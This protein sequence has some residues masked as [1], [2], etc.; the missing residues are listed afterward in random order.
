MYG[1]GFFY[2]PNGKNSTT[3]QRVIQS[4][5]DAQIPGIGKIPDT[6]RWKP[7]KVN[8]WTKW[9]DA[10]WI[11]AQD[12]YKKQGIK[13]KAKWQSILKFYLDAASDK[14][15]LLP[16]VPPKKSAMEKAGEK[17]ARMFNKSR[18]EYLKE[19]KKVTKKPKHKERESTVEDLLEIIASN[20]S[21]GMLPTFQPP[22]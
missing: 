20:S 3:G 18:R 11:Q 7:D 2:D 12:A 14:Y 21:V 17:E 8:P 5:W 4:A 19:T 6:I 13:S 15:H 9:A 10:A 16:G 22:V 1:D